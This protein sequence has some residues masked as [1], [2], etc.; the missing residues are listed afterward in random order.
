MITRLVEAIR[1]EDKDRLIVADGLRWGTKPVLSLAGLES[2]RARAAINPHGSATTSQLDARL[3]PMPEP[4]WPLR[5]TKTMCGQRPPA[6]G[7]DRPWQ[8]LQ[9]KGVGPRRRMGRLPAYATRHRPAWMRDN[10]ELWKEAGWG[11]AMWN[12][13]GSF[14][15]IDTA[16]KTRYERAR[17]QARPAAVGIDPCVL[18]SANAFFMAAA[19]AAQASSLPNSLSAL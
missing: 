19:V 18:G 9:A 10:L 16:E 11:W 8:E 5:S 15:I 1:A 4:T 6:R 14:G 17:P 12:F 7:T 2:L 13:R 3:R